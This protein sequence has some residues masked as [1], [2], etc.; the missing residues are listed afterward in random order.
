MKATITIPENLSEIT[1]GQYQHY[2]KV[3]KDLK[4]DILTQ[5][6][7]N[8]LCDVRLS[9]VMMMRLSDVRDVAEHLQTL[10][11]M[12]HDLT[13]RFKLSSQEFGFI[14]S[15]ED[16]S[17]GEYVDLDKYLNDW[18]T[19]HRA[20]AVLFRPILKKVKDK[21]EIINYSGTDEFAELRKFMPLDVVLGAMVFFYRLGNELLKA[22]RNYSLKQTKE[23]LK[24]T[25]SN[26]NSI[27]NGD[28]TIVSMHSLEEM[29]DT[30]TKLPKFELPK[31]LH[32]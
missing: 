30:L 4:G 23:L 25:A 14:P 5:R 19:M 22:T 12:D 10:F 26:H 13:P 16:I 2:L 28:G 32:I 24:T 31:H 11:S 17:F 27:S 8:T 1:L 18:Q 15:L 3:T 20:M 7:V 9:D 21:Y 29:L 6:T